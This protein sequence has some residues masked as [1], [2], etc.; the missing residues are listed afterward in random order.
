M[1]YTLNQLLNRLKTASSSSRW[2]LTRTNQQLGLEQ[3]R[4]ELEQ[5]RQQLRQARQRL[6]EFRPGWSPT[7]LRKPGFSP[8]TVV[9]VGAGE[10]TPALYKAFPE[11]FHVLIE[12]L[13]ENRPHLQRILQEYEGEYF[14][15][16][17][18]AR[19]ERL[20]INVEPSVRKKSSINSRTDLTSTGDLV[21]RRE[22]PVNTLDA[23]MK[24]HN[25]K[26]PFGL[27]IDTEG[28]EYQVIEGAPRFLRE[29]Q[30]VIAE[31]SVAKRFIQS[32][33]FSEFIQIMDR[34]GFRLNDILNTRR[35]KSSV[36]ELLFIDAMFR[37][38]GT[39]R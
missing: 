34:N 24:K 16:A 39:E 19:E 3:T 27:K 31:V 20:N 6:K 32:Y 4:Q 5:T 33:S 17:I 26:P 7:S 30:F 9:D 37:R 38:D 36:S 35:T 22:I 23:L 1:K 21:E 25:F 28:F 11:A 18:G 13:K 10:G 2:Q 15:T 8:S 29:T 14:L 12:P